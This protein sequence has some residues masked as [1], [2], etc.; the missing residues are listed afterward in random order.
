MLAGQA[1][2]RLWQ[3]SPF[4][5]GSPISKEAITSIRDVRHL[6]LSA[7]RGVPWQLE[8]WSAYDSTLLLFRTFLPLLFFWN[9]LA[10]YPSSLW[11]PYNENSSW[12]VPCNLWNLSASK[13]R[14]SAHYRNTKRAPFK[15][16][17]VGPSVCCCW[18]R[19]PSEHNEQRGEGRGGPLLLRLPIDHPPNPYGGF[20][21]QT[22]RVTEVR[23]P[24]PSSVG[25]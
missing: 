5:G 7:G 20:V 17:L 2:W 10:L 13:G 9:K 18:P 4:S 8:L 21:A 22:I 3:T 23:A 16:Q 19:C 11:A 1:P 24:A 25:P 15:A 12:Q 14:K 6:A